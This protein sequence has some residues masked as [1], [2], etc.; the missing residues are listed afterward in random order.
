MKALTKHGIGAFRERVVKHVVAYKRRAWNQLGMP[1]P[2]RNPSTDL[3][4][5]KLTVAPYEITVFT[6]DV[7]DAGVDSDVTITIFG[8]EGSTPEVKLEK[9]EEKFE[10]G[11]V[12]MFRMELEDVGKLRKMRIG[13]EG[14][15]NRVNWYLDKVRVVTWLYIFIH[16]IKKP[17]IIVFD[18]IG[19]T[20]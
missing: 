14:E 1:A 19:I 18:V 9:G 8:S 16:L 7:K 11:G 15:G 17:S 2:A 5:I 20:G 13:H 10:R 12:D 4:F 3:F 6:G